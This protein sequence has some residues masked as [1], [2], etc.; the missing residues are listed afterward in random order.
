MRPHSG[1]EAMTPLEGAL[2][3]VGQAEPAALLLAV[4]VSASAL[5]GGHLEFAV[6]QILL[7]LKS[8]SR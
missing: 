4:D 6:Q 7:L 1:F 8:L 2:V 5:R 3:F